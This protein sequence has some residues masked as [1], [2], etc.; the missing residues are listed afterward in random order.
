MG[1]TGT[2]LIR[3]MEQIAPP[4]LAVPK[5]RIG[6]QVG[7]PQQE[8]KGVLLTLDVTEAVIDEAIQKGLNWIITHH[9]ILYRP[10]TTIDTSTPK[11]RLLTKA[12][13]HEIN[14]LVAHT[15]LDTAIG[16]VNDVL[17]QRL[18]LQS[19]KPLEIHYIESLV[20]LVVTVPISH[21]QQV[22]RAITDA[23]AGW[24]GNYSHCTFRQQ[25]TGT[26]LPQSGTNPFIGKAGKLEEV[27]ET[28]LE[29]ILP[30][31]LTNKV[32]TALFANHPYEEVAYDLYPL[33][34]AGKEYGLGRIGD[35]EKE[36]SLE[37]LI[38]VIKKEYQVDGLRLVG[39]PTKKIKRVAVLGGAGGRYW[40]RALKQGADVLITGDLDFHT[41]QDAWLAGFVLIDPGH[42]I[43]HLALEPLKENL[44][45]ALSQ[46]A[47]TVSQVNTNPFQFR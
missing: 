26:F 25:G 20:K 16:G 40:P 23:G 1:V 8:V 27:A 22:I 46:L 44:Q 2:A 4:S 28:R 15:N 33:K 30:E 21:E 18:Q 7:N 39:D 47:I 43:E 42:H 45:G 31:K 17:A 41:A 37:Q 9:A 10:L 29:T 3:V 38:K 13:A 12:L 32:L 35:L 14:I 34:Q 11:G 19:V 5:D 36:L 6:L 24:I